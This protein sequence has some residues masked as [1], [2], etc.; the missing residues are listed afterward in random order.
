MSQ[1]VRDSSDSG[2]TT[3]TSAQTTRR[4]PRCEPWVH[5]SATMLMI[6]SWVDRY[7]LQSGPDHAEA[8]L[9]GVTSDRRL[10][11]QPP[12]KPSGWAGPGPLPPRGRASLK[13]PSHW[14]VQI[15]AESRPAGAAPV[16]QPV[17]DQPRPMRDMRGLGTAGPGV[18]LERDRVSSVVRC[19]LE[20]GRSTQILSEL[21]LAEC[22]QQN[23]PCWRRIERELSAD[24]PAPERRGSSRVL[25]S[26]LL[27]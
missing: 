21:V 9:S 20:E 11:G 17:P 24:A 23:L 16:C 2:G 12:I 6:L 7:R 18:R 27:A 22:A 13:T 1:K 4:L 3:L 10:D 5:S 19:A 8:D 14:M 25:P 26:L 15:C